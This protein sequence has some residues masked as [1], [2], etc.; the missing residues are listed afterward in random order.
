MSY[1]TTGLDLKLDA[2]AIAGEPV[3]G[4]S[5]YDAT[6]YE[7]LTQVERVVISGGTFGQNFIQPADWYWARAWPRGAIQLVQPYNQAMTISAVF[8]AGSN[9]VTVSDAALPDLSG[10]RIFQADVAARHMIDFTQ[11][12][13][14]LGQITLREPWTGVSET[15]SDWIAYPDTYALPLDF[16]RGLSP[17]FVYS[18]P[19]TFPGTTVI[20]VIDPGDLEKA[21]PQTFPWGGAASPTT[22]G[23][24][25]PLLAARVTDS[26]LRFSHFLNTPSTPQN[27]QL[28][29]EYIRRPPVIAEGVIPSIP[30]QHRR[31][32]SY[33]AA[34]LILD[35]KQDGASQSKY[36]QFLAQYQA[37]RDEHARDMR[38]M[39][40]RWGVV[41]PARAGGNWSFR[42]TESGLPVYVW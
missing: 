4:T 6:V 9:I 21:Y 17:I 41:Q 13:G 23:G 18:F 39:S 35:D 22:V 10:Y 28:E 20:D 7:W 11:D 3:D 12:L 34:Y 26:R 31:I 8:N 14:P 33:G 30:I 24:G 42:L 29:F 27:V 15:I 16:V 36:Q 32:L 2:L 40:T 19:T 37:M 5:Q 38:R 1:L 25:Y